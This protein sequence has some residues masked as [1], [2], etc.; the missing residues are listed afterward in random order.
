MHVVMPSIS[1]IY[2]GTVLV[3][4]YSQRH[5]GQIAR[6]HLRYVLTREV[7]PW[8]NRLITNITDPINNE[9]SE[10]YSKQYIAGGT[11]IVCHQLL[12][13]I[14]NRIKNIKRCTILTP[15][16]SLHPHRT[17]P[18]YALPQSRSH[19]IKHTTPTLQK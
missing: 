1:A 18:K 17:H 19:I 11:E 7:T 9:D 12:Q 8:I 4:N 10:L 16:G 13:N 15:R 2:Q 6:M 14:S 5:V 3:L